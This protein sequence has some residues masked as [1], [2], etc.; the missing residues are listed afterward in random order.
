[1]KVIIELLKNILE[2]PFELGVC[3]NHLIFLF[4]FSLLLEGIITKAQPI[5]VAVPVTDYGNR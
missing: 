5:F 2:F 4:C 1:M 3:M